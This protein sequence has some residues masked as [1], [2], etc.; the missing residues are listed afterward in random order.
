M[1]PGYPNV[2][3]AWPLGNQLQCLTTFIIKKKKNPYVTFKHNFFGLKLIVQS[4]QKLKKSLSIFL[5]YVPNILKGCS[6]TGSLILVV[7]ARGVQT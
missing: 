1:R 5:L 7:L 4:L 2:Y 6:C 3:P